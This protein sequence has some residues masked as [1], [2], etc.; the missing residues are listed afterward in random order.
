MSTLIT[1]GNNILG[2]LGTTSHEMAHAWFQHILANNEANTLG[3]TRVL[4]LTLMFW[5]KTLF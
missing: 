2:L 3:W 1:G 5:Q 4:R